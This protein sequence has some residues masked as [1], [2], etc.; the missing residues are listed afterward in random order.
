VSNMLFVDDM[1]PL[2]VVIIDPFELQPSTANG[3][4]RRR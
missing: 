4:L 3:C 2:L 1:N